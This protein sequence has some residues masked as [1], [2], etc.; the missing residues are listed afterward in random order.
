[1]LVGVDL[2]GI[3]LEIDA[4]QSHGTTTA[5]CEIDPNPYSWVYQP[6]KRHESHRIICTGNFSPANNAA[7]K[8][9]ATVEFTDS[10]SDEDIKSQLP[11]MPFHPR[12]IKSHYS[13]YTYPVQTVRTRAMISQLKAF[14]RHYGISLVGRFA[15]WEYFNMD[16]AMASAFDAVGL[17]RFS[18]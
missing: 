5:F 2:Q 6:S 10:I 17:L 18:D 8:M 14:L 3:G 1:M 16:A 9:T 11:L 12:F 4:L 7:G 13:K 15:E